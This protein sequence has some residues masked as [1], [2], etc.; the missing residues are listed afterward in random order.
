MVLVGA[1]N[2]ASALPRFRNPGFLPQRRGRLREHGA[3]AFGEQ[4]ADVGL[5]DS[6][7][8]QPA[9]IGQTR[10]RAF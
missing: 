2:V 7:I 9:R 10:L 1:R 3:I 4:H 8:E 6:L 5:G